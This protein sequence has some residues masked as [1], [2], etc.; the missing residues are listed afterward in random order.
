MISCKFYLL[1]CIVGDMSDIPGCVEVT[2]LFTVGVVFELGTVV[3]VFVGAVKD[4][5]SYC[6]I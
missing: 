3:S 4:S 1:I 2:G 6:R 5:L